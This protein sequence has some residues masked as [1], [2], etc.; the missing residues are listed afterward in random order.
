MKTNVGQLIGVRIKINARCS[1]L[2]SAVV[3][4]AETVLDPSLPTPT[5]KWKCL[6]NCDNACEA[7]GQGEKKS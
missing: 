1:V 6:P 7:A 4:P 3:W 5:Q 2:D